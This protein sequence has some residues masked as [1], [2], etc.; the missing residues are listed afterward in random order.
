MRCILNLFPVSAP[1]QLNKPPATARA[2]SNPN[3]TNVYIPYPDYKMEDPPGA[4]G[5][6]FRVTYRLAGKM[7]AVR[8]AGT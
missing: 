7:V 3:G 4:G 6:T 1:E 2:P 8:A 5:E